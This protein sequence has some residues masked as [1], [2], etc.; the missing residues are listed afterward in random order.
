MVDASNFEKPHATK[1]VSQGE[2]GVNVPLFLKIKPNVPLF[3]KGFF[4]IYFPIFPK[5]YVLKLM[6]PCSLKENGH[7]PLFP[8]NP[9]ET[10]NKRLQIT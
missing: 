3:P 6:F 4:L 10:L 7:V 9:W 1:R 8:K 5:I 2:G